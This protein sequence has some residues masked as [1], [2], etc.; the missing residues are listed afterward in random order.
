MAEFLTFCNLL[1]KLNA[2][3]V[4]PPGVP[5]LFTVP[6]LNGVS[7]SFF[8]CNKDSANYVKKYFVT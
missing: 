5:L 4:A 6:V 8:K 3:D 7:S 1:S 2:E